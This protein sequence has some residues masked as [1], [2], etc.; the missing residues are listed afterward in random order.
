MRFLLLIRKPFTKV[1]VN[2]TRHVECGSATKDTFV[3][4]VQENGEAVLVKTGTFDQHD[5]IQSFASDVDINKLVQRYA[6]GDVTAFGAPGGFYGDVSGM[7]QNLAEVFNLNQRSHSFFENLPDDLKKDFGSYQEFM[8]SFSSK[9]KFLELNTKVNAF[10][11]S[12]KKNK[13]L[14]LTPK[15]GDLNEQK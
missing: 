9:D 7:P 12:K 5:Y 11:E 15:G 6:N 2:D 1:E 8:E 4:V 13:E 3:K 10:F 14:D